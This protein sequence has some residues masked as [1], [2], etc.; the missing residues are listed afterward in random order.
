MFNLY[1]KVLAAESLAQVA[2]IGSISSAK[3]NNYVTWRGFG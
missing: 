2:T 3:G 1:R